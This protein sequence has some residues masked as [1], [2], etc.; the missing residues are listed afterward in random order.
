MIAKLISYSSRSRSDALNGLVEQI[1][2]S[3]WAHPVKTNAGFLRTL[4]DHEEF[5]QARLNTGFIDQHLEG[6]LNTPTESLLKICAAMI[7]FRAPTPA[8]ADVWGDRSG[9]RINANPSLRS[10]FQQGV[11]R[12]SVQATQDGADNWR[13]R[14]DGDVFEVR[15]VFIDGDQH[16]GWIDFESD[17]GP[18]VAEY[19]CPADAPGV[20]RV[21]LRG[22]FS[23]FS[24]FNPDALA[25]AADASSV[26]KAPMPGKVLAV[27]VAEGDSVTKGQA[28]VVLEAMKM[29]HALTAPRDGVIA[30]LSASVDAQVADG[31]ILVALAEDEA[32]A[33]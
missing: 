7:V 16:K 17:Y 1:D 4:L 21:S 22:E 13:L 10:T 28:L 11:D 26:I 14:I 5:R 23:V 33:A 29:E 3:C 12:I 9:F 31:D 6:L 20:I 2:S 32:D 30:Q 15:D 18:I 25:D 8:A 27:N 24:P 19:S